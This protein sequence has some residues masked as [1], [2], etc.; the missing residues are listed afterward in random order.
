MRMPR[1]GD[2]AGGAKASTAE[3][4]V[5]NVGPA[6]HVY[7]LFFGVWLFLFLMAGVGAVCMMHGRGVGVHA[8]GGYD[9]GRGGGRG[10]GGPFAHLY[11][12]AT[13]GP[14]GV[15]PHYDWTLVRRRMSRHSHC[16]S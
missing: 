16:S 1:L 10:G 2:P 12:N 4:G 7:H 6:P 3:W 13:V 14:P 9:A 8:A 15:Q 11:S 5:T